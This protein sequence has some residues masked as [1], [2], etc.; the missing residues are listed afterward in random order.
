MSM[1]A[2]L[3]ER[4]LGASCPEGGGQMS[5]DLC[6]AL[7]IAADI[8][9]CRAATQQLTCSVHLSPRA[10]IPRRAKPDATPSPESTFTQSKNVVSSSPSYTVLDHGH[11]SVACLFC[12]KVTVARYLVNQSINI[13]LLRH[14]KMQANRLTSIHGSK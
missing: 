14:D 1:T 7:G 2:G 13:C 12:R 3:V 11:V 9:E 10:S 8:E 5:G 4:C 6:S